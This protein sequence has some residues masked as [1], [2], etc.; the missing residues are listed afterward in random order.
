MN[1]KKTAYKLIEDKFPVQKYRELQAERER[2]LEFWKEKKID[3]LI[4]HE[5]H[6]INFGKRVLR[7]LEENEIFS[8]LKSNKF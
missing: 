7:I 8:V 4:Y 5:Q 6:I 2:R 3:A 1:A